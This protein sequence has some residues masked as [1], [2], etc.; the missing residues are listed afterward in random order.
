MSVR[1]LASLLPG[2]KYGH[3]VFQ[4]ELA[5]PAGMQYIRKVWYVDGTNGDDNDTG[6][7]EN[8]AFAT[9]QQAVDSVSSFD[10]IQVLPATYTENIDVPLSGGARSV[11]LAGY[12]NGLRSENRATILGTGASDEIIDVRAQGWRITGFRIAV[13]AANAGI[14]LRHTDAAEASGS[15]VAPYTTIDNNLFYASLYGIHYDGA[16][17]SVHIAHNEFLS[18]T[19]AIYQASTGIKAAGNWVI[20][21]NFFNGN[22]NHINHAGGTFGN[23]MIINNQFSNGATRNIW[24]VAGNN[25]TVTGNSFGGAYTQAGG[26]YAGTGGTSNLWAGNHIEGGLSTT[27]PA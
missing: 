7:S 2:I 18:N 4:N 6:E 12:Y 14:R 13:A 21:D 15:S 1:N 10:W 25:N 17:H 27:V 19:T 16:P 9:I 26:Y 3:R 5:Q 23:G 20:R 22:T 11:T 24:F 8:Q